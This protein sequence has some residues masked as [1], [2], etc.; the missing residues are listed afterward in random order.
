MTLLSILQ[1]A[2]FTAKDLGYILSFIVT[3]LVAWFKY[4]RNTDQLKFRIDQLEK[5]NQEVK[6]ELNTHREELKEVTL[7][8]SD[9]K[10]I[11]EKISILFK[12]LQS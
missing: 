1:E 11:R 9:I 7:M 10:Y 2:A 3:I 5:E 8:K 6:T 12:K 4:Q